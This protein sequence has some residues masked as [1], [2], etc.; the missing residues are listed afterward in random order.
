MIVRRNFDEK[1][2]GALFVR[3]FLE[4]DPE[5]P[6]DPYREEAL[7]TFHGLEIQPAGLR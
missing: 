6:V 7:S 3:F 1:I 4:K 2:I 5:V